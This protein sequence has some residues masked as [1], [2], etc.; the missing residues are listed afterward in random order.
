MISFFHFKTNTA[1][2]SGEIAALPY[3]Q[4]WALSIDF[5]N[6]TSAARVGIDWFCTKVFPFLERFLHLILRYEHGEK[7]SL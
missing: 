1:I 6:K 4:V 5:G 7:P 3:L 2:N